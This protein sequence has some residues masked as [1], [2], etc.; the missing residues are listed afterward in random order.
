MVRGRRLLAAVLLVVALAAALAA[1]IVWHV[2]RSALDSPR[3]FASVGDSVLFVVSSGETSRQILERLESQ[4]IVASALAARAYLSRLLDDPPLLAGEYRIV[5]PISTIELLRMLRAGEVVTYPVTIVEGLTYFETADHL[6]AHGFGD[7]TALL[8]ELADPGRI[9]ELDPAASN[10]EGY[11]FPDTYRFPRGT[12]AKRV[13]DTLVASFRSRFESAVRPAFA[14]EERRSLRELVI[15]ASLVEKEA[16]VD[17]ERPLIAAVYANRLRRGIGLYADPTIIYGLKLAGRWDGDLRRRDL[18]AD[19]PWN[20]YRQ[21][22]LPPGPICSPG[23]ASLLAAVR[24]ARVDYLYFVSKND[25]THLFS[26]SLA[27][28]NRNVEVWQRRFFRERRR[29]A[30]RRSRRARCVAE[31]GLTGSQPRWRLSPAEET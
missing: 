7:R 19:S 27:E 3:D 13:G 2:A 8:G 6:A 26:A 10:L 21:P 23:L 30:P 28:H 15:L 4:G 14:P 12:S 9:A 5:S 11:L 31:H 17:A 24:P 1:G 20:S 16:K 22:G 25:G 18:E 29:S